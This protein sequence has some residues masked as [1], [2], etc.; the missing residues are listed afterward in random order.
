MKM[1][2]VHNDIAI[3]GGGIIGASVAWRLAQ[4]QFR[5]T[6]YDAGPLGSEASSAGAGMLAPGGE[7]SEETEFAALLIRSLRLYPSFVEELSQAAASPIDFAICGAIEHAST[8]AV[9]ETTQG[10]AALQ[11]RLGI[12]SERISPCEF[13]YPDDGYVNPVDVMTALRVALRRS[14]VAI[15]EHSPVR[16]LELCSA[17]V[18]IDGDRVRAA[19]LAAGAWSSLISIPGATLPRAYPVKGHLLGYSLPPGLL[20]SIHRG[21][22]AYVFQRANGFTIVGAS[23]ED[24]GFDKSVDPAIAAEVRRSGEALVPELLSYSPVQV[25]T[26]LRPG[27]DA[28]LFHRFDDTRLWLAY[29]H[30]RNGIRAAPAA[31]ERLSAEISAALTSN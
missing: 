1:R 16:N 17:G 12:R 27:A 24:A 31:A 26:G 25:W 2:D 14:N 28:P 9:A 29:G 8:T 21:N 4:R 18:L 5:V 15:R 6:I 7:V 23:Q 11:E 19:V 3:I 13:F 22:H 10:R 30:F 20:R